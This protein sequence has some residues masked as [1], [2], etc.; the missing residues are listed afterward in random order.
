MRVTV[1]GADGMLGQAVMNRLAAF[2][3][4]G[5]VEP[6]FKLEDRKGVLTAI[7]DSEPDWVVHIAAMT[8]VDGC[9]AEPEAAF[10]INALGTRNV[11]MACALCK[12]GMIYISTDFVFGEGAD[13]RAIQAWEH[14]VPRSM[15]GHSKW[16]GER[17]VEAIAPRFMI[18]RTA[19][20]YGSGG[21]H[22]VGTILNVARA[23]KPLRVVNDQT[24]SPS[25]ATDV[26]GG[27]AQLLEAGVPGW[28]HVVNTGEAT[29]F[30]FA[31]AAVELVGM[32]PNIVSPCTTREFPR[33]APR[34]AYSVL[35]TYTFRETTGSDFRPWRDG[36]EE[37]LEGERGGH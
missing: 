27:I 23:G 35:S 33:P 30:E 15:Y 18:A 36:L 21:R 4:T 17:Y 3:P 32:D 14:P 13:R 2:E 37:F 11:A 12:A 19:W 1:T 20:L 31:R 28:Y 24:G 29:W 8:D 25:Y 16:A 9:E 6:D 10:R 22:F 26:A 7:A 5:L 34:P